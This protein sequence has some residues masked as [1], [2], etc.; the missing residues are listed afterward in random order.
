[1]TVVAINHST[2]PEYTQMV[3]DLAKDGQAIIDSATP[4]ATH[5]LHMA[6]GIC[7][8]VGEKFEALLLKDRVNL[9]EECGDLEFY[10]EGVAFTMREQFDVPDLHESVIQSYIES[11]G[12]QERK[13]LLVIVSARLLD[14][15]KK[16]WAYNKEP[17]VEQIYTNVFALRSLLDNFY[18]A[19]E[20]KRS[21]MLDGNMHKLLKGDTARYKS[22]TYSDEQAVA[23]ADKTVGG[24]QISV[25]LNG[26]S[27]EPADLP[28]TPDNTGV[29]LTWS[30][31]RTLAYGDEKAVGRNPTMTF[32][33]RN[34]NLPAREGMLDRDGLPLF[35]SD[36]DEAIINCMETGNA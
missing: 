2:P 30:Q 11:I 25:V 9:R 5:L 12:T 10:L 6:V 17:N 3:K 19:Y 7:G 33:V 24:M 21:E 35:L 27:L 13:D 31:I 23:R 22:G 36:G 4:L 34:P 14:Y 15:I 32:S 28:L 18:A 16:M 29:A 26:R 20:F 1:M 8:E